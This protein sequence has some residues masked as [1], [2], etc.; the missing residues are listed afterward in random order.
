MLKKF[1]PLVLG[2]VLRTAGSCLGDPVDQ[3][4]RDQQADPDP[5]LPQGRIE[6][7]EEE[8]GKAFVFLFTIVAVVISVE[9]GHLCR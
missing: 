5:L 4:H 1:W 7:Q 2:C 8:E 3:R 6:E 9:N